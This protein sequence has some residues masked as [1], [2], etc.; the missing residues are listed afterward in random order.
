M[1]AGRLRHRIVIQTM[2]DS[3]G[4]Q[5]GLTEV[6]STFAQVPADIIPLTGSEAFRSQQVFPEATHRIELRYLAGVTPK[7]RVAYGTRIFDILI[8]LN[9]EERNRELHLIVKER[10]N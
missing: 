6:P 7:M 1:R 9:L 4:S 3:V 5:G 2:T 8:P 10:L